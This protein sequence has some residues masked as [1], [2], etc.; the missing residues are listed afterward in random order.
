MVEEW[1]LRKQEAIKLMIEVC[2]N[3]I[4]EL[5]LEGRKEEIVS[6]TFLLTEYQ[7]MLE[8]FEAYYNL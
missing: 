1:I 7:N 6:E 5:E 3:K 4:G 8:E 2:Q